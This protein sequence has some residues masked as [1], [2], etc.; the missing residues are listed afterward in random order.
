MWTG[1]VTLA[2]AAAAATAGWLLARHRRRRS[3]FTAESPLRVHVLRALDAEQR[4]LATRALGPHVRLTD[5]NGD[6]TAECHA[7][8]RALLAP[9]VAGA[10][11]ERKVHVLVHGH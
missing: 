4:A 11:G 6:A 3:A 8:A 9:C 1:R 5:L 2:A 7:D 10:G